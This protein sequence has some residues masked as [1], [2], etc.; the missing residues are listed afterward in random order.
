MRPPQTDR[1][2]LTLFWG[3]PLEMAAGALQFWCGV[4]A[5][6]HLSAD[7]REDRAH[8]QLVVPDALKGKDDHDLFA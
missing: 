3:L 8:N 7:Q 1:D 6:S 5:S 2:P 4:F